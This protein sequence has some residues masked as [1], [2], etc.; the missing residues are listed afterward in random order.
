ML[1][2]DH[3]QSVSPTL[4]VTIFTKPSMGEAGQLHHTCKTSSHH[5][6]LFPVKQHLVLLVPLYHRFGDRFLSPVRGL[7]TLYQYN[8]GL[9]HRYFLSAL[10]NELFTNRHHLSLSWHVSRSIAQPQSCLEGV[11]GRLELCLLINL[12]WFSRPSVVAKLGQLASTSRY[13]VVSSAGLKPRSC[14]TYPLE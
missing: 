14:T 10:Y 8:L 7:G 12:W 3:H 2:K 6:S 9:Y 5:L 1:T 13:R 4:Q 11:E